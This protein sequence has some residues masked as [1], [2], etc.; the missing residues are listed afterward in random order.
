[1]VLKV[2]N[3]ALNA[4]RKKLALS[5][6]VLTVLLFERSH[7]VVY[8]FDFI[9][10]IVVHAKAR[11]QCE[12]KKTNSKRPS[13]GTL[14]SAVRTINSPYLKRFIGARAQPINF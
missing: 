13:S 10:A 9:V 7:R 6:N 3:T 5:R 12:T 1:M 4:K 14:R 11:S 2:I 8:K